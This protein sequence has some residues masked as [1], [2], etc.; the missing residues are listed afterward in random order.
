MPDQAFKIALITGGSRA[1]AAI[2]PS[3]SPAPASTS[4]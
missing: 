3:T 1:S 2:P 4:F